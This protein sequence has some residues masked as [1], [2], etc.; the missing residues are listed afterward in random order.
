MSDGSTGV[1]TA[2]DGDAARRH[3]LLS[4][5]A[6]ESGASGP[7]VVCKL[8]EAGVHEVLTGKAANS[9]LTV[10]EV[11]FA[12]KRMTDLDYDSSEVIAALARLESAGHV[13]F[14]HAERRAF[15]FSERRQKELNADLQYRQERMEAV[16]KEWCDDVAL[17]HGLSDEQ[18]KMLW[19]ALDEFIARLM[20]T[21]AA[22]AAAFLYQ[23]ENGTERFAEVLS[24]RLPKISDVVA[25]D[26]IAVA[27]P[28]FKLFFD[29]P[30]AARTDYLV[31]RL[32]S[33]FHFHL[34]N[35]DPAASQL[36]QE[37]VSNKV[38][39]LDTNFLFRLL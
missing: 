18:L 39:Y 2:I 11:R 27:E 6:L 1:R 8:V 34:L 31:H 32:R 19:V 23:A 26:L 22:E 36:V 14:R 21:Y 12:I 30:T 15:V 16:R 10:D 17:R 24:Q 35:I 28:E 7:E 5:P 20:N 38:F 3:L 37:H 25:V 29:Q 9:L 4:F 33:A 13:S